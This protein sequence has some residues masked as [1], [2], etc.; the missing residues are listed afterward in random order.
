[1]IQSKPIR[2]L[3][4]DDSALVRKMLVAALAGDKGIEIVG[5][6]P[7]A[8]IARDKILALNPDVIT[9][10]IEMPRMDGITFLKKLMRFRPLP[11]IIISSLGHSA[12][13]ASLEALRA[14]AVEILCKPNGP[15]S[16]GE[17][18]LTLGQKIRAAASSHVTPR[19]IDGDSAVVV[20]P[21]RVNSSLLAPSPTVQFAR[22]KIILIG[23]ST[24]GPTA[25][26]EV[27]AGFPANAP[28]IL[29][30]QH[31]PPVFTAHFA[32]RLKQ[33]CKIDVK[34]AEDGD[35]LLVGRALIAP[36]NFH[37]TLRQAESGYRVRIDTGPQVCFS[38][39][40]V[41]V[42]FYSASNVARKNA[43][44]VLL[45]GMGADGARG[46]LEMR[47]N[48]AITIAQDEES[49]VVFGMPKEA[50]RMGAVETVLPLRQI[51][52]AIL[53]RVMLTPAA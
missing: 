24:G 11:V 10:D 46:L 38:R 19:R 8:Y 26:A 2:L 45:T 34:E 14:G 44:G 40:S 3:I 31:M 28:P 41:D 5:T 25:V 49:C 20:H 47:N 7:D 32:A 53:R 30:V 23:A 48:G 13:E 18:G 6:A 42:L 33:E 35:A 1:M 43:I 22:D 51:A 52:P 36:G 21:G 50:I 15:C 9:L 16:V 17:L 27:L 29:V 4:V 37:M 39:P 12:C